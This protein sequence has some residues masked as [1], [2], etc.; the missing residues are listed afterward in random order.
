MAITKRPC[1]ESMMTE[2]E[3][4]EEA[5]TLPDPEAVLTRGVLSCF[6][7]LLGDQL[8]DVLKGFQRNSTCKGGLKDRCSEN[9]KQRR[10]GRQHMGG[11]RE[12]SG[13]G[14]GTWW[15]VTE[16]KEPQEGGLLPGQSALEPWNL[17]RGTL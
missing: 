8:V 6:T 17:G 16:A 12:G 7:S 3:V 4:K 1:A 13:I 14:Q 5:G 9:A 11:G 15:E 10:K 2:C